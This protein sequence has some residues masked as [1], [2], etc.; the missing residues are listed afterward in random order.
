MCRICGSDDVVIRGDEIAL[1]C[2]KC[3]E[4]EMNAAEDWR[5]DA[6]REKKEEVV[7]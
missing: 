4:E 6:E 1:V 5:E 3:R 7:L 2:E